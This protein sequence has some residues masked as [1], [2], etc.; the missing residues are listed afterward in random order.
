M[1][2]NPAGIGMCPVPVGHSSLYRV[3]AQTQSIKRRQ[4][5]D[6]EIYH[7]RYGIGCDD[8]AILPN[9]LKKIILDNQIRVG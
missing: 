6:F 7:I 2:Y 4:R 9:K 1:P 5:A 3:V 8:S